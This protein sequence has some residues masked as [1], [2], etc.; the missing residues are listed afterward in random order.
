MTSTAILSKL[1]ELEYAN[2]D[3]NPIIAHL[4]DVWK[5]EELQAIA[6]KDGGSAIKACIAFAKECAKRD[7]QPALQ[8]AFMQDGSQWL[9]NGYLGVK[10]SNPIDGLPQVDSALATFDLAAV[11]NSHEGN[12]VDMPLDNLPS[13]G[14]L[15]AELAGYKAAHDAAY[16][17]HNPA[18]T[19]IK[20]TDEGAPACYDCKLLMM[21]LECAG[22]LDRAT[23][24]IKTTK[25]HNG[26]PCNIGPIM[27]YGDNATVIVLPIRR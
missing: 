11:Y 9:C 26:E 22:N 6:G 1:Q 10:M 21:A 23:V 27:L 24:V 12:A 17:K 8:G 19:D 4:L 18:T 3:N 7:I 20:T 16:R 15:R 14:K 25:D 2:M 13:V 5:R